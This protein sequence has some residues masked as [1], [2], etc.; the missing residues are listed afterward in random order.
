MHVLECVAVRWVVSLG[1]PL[2]HV[3][4]QMRNKRPAVVACIAKAERKKKKEEE[5]EER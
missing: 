4:T 5:E 1:V 3:Y 2:T